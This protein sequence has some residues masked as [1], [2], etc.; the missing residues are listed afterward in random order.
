MTPEP[1]KQTLD[2]LY[3]S[4]VKTKDSRAMSSI[5]DNLNNDIDKAV[6]AYAG[7]N[8]GPAVRTK[9]KLLAAKAVKSYTPKAGSTLRSWVYTQLQPVGRYARDLTPSPVP[10]RAFQQ[11]SSLK[12]MEA[13]FYENKGRSPSDAELADL[14]SISTRQIAKLRT[15]DKKLFS[16]SHQAYS[17]P[18]PMS[19]Q[20]LTAVDNKGFKQDV[21]ATMYTSLSAPEQV[22]LEHKLGYNNKQI[23]SNNDIAKKLKMSPGRVSQLTTALASKLDE[24]ASISKGVG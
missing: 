14:S 15:Y 17:G 2:S 22:I 3:D 20:E 9:A 1:Q 11:L 18:N 10:E 21:L 13:D 16:E 6:Y 23:L 5:L 8:A 19:A 24:Y 7:L 4:W 12:R